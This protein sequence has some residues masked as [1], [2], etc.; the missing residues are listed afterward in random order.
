[1]VNQQE[2]FRTKK[3]WEIKKF[4]VEHMFGPPVAIIEMPPELTKG[5]ILLTDKVLEKKNYPSHGDQ[6][7][8]Q[9]YHEPTLS[10][11][12]LDVVG[13]AYFFHNC[14]T[15]YLH[16]V[17]S[18]KI[19]NLEKD[20]VLQIFFTSIWAVSQREANITLLTTILIVIFLRSVTSK[21]QI[22]KNVGDKIAALKENRATAISSL[23]P[24]PWIMVWRM[25]PIGTHLGLATSSYSHLTLFTPYILFSV[26]A[27]GDQSHLIWDIS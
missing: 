11:E 14:A 16:N 6:L 2:L 21:F 15:H 7:A 4:S 5:L 23:S 17:L 12:M 13:A 27:R 9:I 25:G 19:R 20:Y 1:M 22:I 10:L 8:G 24:N 3:K 18:K 26:R